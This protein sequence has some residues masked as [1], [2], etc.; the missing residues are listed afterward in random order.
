MALAVVA[1]IVAFGLVYQ[2][3]KAEAGCAWPTT[4]SD[5]DTVGPT[6]IPG[7]GTMSGEVNIQH[8]WLFATPLGPGPNA[9]LIHYYCV[10]GEV[11]T[12]ASVSVTYAYWK[13]QLYSYLV[14][15]WELAEE[16]DDDCTTCTGGEWVSP[17]MPLVIGGTLIKMDGVHKA[18]QGAWVWY[19]TSR[20][21]APLPG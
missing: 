17:F 7:G 8:R 16:G 13:G 12:D 18:W 4:T 10:H 21:S 6:D 5:Y 20:A 1:A 19:R 2:P 3:Q 15:D 11:M 9:P 14:D